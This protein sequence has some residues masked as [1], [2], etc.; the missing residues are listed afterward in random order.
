MNSVALREVVH[1]WPEGPPTKL[2]GVGP[3]TEFRGLAGVSVDTLML[4]NVSEPTLTVFRPINVKPNGIGVIV[5]PGGGWRILAWQHEGIDV[6]LWLA[7]RGYTAFLLKYRVSGTPVAAAEF[8]AAMAAMSERIALPRSGKDAPR[9]MSDIVP[10]ESFGA[11]LQYFTGSKQ[12]NVVLRGRAKAAG[13][14]VNEWGVFRDEKY[15]GGR[16]DRTYVIAQAIEI[17]LAQD[18]D[19]QKS[20]TSR[21]AG[22]AAGPART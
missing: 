10:A 22:P 2:E 11:A 6:A 12:H 20:L 7:E 17:T 9:A 15:L 5:C 14:K 13:L 8:E 3:E 4:R 21:A 16:T 19:F 1:L 18:A